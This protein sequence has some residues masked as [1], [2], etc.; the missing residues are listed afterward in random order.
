M[1][2]QKKQNQNFGKRKMKLD[3]LNKIS[4]QKILDKEL[5]SLHRRIH[6]LYGMTKKKKT[7]P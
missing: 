2:Y 3:E 6:Q 5:I 4:V 1:I 7:K